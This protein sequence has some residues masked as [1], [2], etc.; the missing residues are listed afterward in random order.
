MKT[1]KV[2]CWLILFLNAAPLKLAQAQVLINEVMANPTEGEEKI[3]LI[4]NLDTDITQIDLENWSLW[5]ELSQPSSLHQF[6]SIQLI[7]SQFL[8]IEINGKLNNN[9]DS[10]T[11]KNSVGEI[12]SKFTYTQTEKGLSFCRLPTDFDPF[13]QNLIAG[14]PSFGQVNS[15]PSSAPSSAPSPALSPSPLINTTPTTAVI[16][17]SVIAPPT[18]AHVPTTP[19]PIILKQV[20]KWPSPSASPLNPSLLKKIQEKISSLENQ[21]AAQ[22]ILFTPSAKLLPKKDRQSFATQS[23][24]PKAVMFVIIGGLCFVSA[25]YLLYENKK[26]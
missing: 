12:I 17:N 5:D 24:S 18:M 22:K 21:Y 8:V 26:N 11:L 25:S 19:T 23:R 1:K 6:E 10:V 9:G 2:L 13:S 20:E 15:V 4:I 14:T 7:K 3:E 16:N